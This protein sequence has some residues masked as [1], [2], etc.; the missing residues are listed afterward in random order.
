MVED[1][2]RR[3][4]LIDREWLSRGILENGARRGGLG[5]GI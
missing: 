4:F 1:K 3:I 2:M 5:P